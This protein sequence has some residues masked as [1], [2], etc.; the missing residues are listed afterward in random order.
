MKKILTVAL[1]FALVASFASGLIT[2]NVSACTARYADPRLG[3][4]VCMQDGDDILNIDEIENFGARVLGTG[5][6]KITIPILYD[7]FHYWDNASGDYVDSATAGYAAPS[8][9]DDWVTGRMRIVFEDH[10]TA[11][12]FD[13]KTY[14]SFNSLDQKEA[15]IEIIAR[16]IGVCKG[17]FWIEFTHDDGTYSESMHYETNGRFIDPTINKEIVGL[18]GKNPTE[19]EVTLNGKDITAAEV[20]NLGIIAPESELHFLLDTEF[21]DWDPMITGMD[22]TVR[23]ST[24][25]SYKIGV[26]TNYIRGSKLVDSV[27]IKNIDGVAYIVVEFAEIF[28][29]TEDKDFDF[30][31][32]LT[33][34]GNAHAGTLVEIS[35]TLANEELY[36]DGLDYAYIGD[37]TIA[38]TDDVVRN[39]ELDL[40][41]GVSVFRTLMKD[42][43]YFGIAKDTVTQ[44]D[45]DIMDFYPSIRR[46]L[47]LTTLNLKTS[48]DIVKINLTVDNSDTEDRLP[49]NDGKAYYVYDANGKYLGTTD[50]MLPYRDVY[51][52]STGI[53]TVES[54]V[55]EPEEEIIDNDNPETGSENTAA[56]YLLASAL[57]ALGAVTA[58]RSKRLG[59][60]NR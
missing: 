42:K 49:S 3:H 26:K 36:V 34:R 48:G 56:P 32:W 11:A 25:D 20:S 53:I 58:Y 5:G 6:V 31:I 50:G 55:F 60:S 9:I 28:P 57:M 21:F 51:Y 59:G 40:G 41:N 29:S 24:L 12:I 2:L 14:I 7:G 1:A 54:A 37:G 33:Y 27:E 43:K 4:S 46:V 47:N 16:N 8:L 19:L 30:R 35:G 45:Q 38:R 17:E 13:E 52:L 18:T 44:N 39:I 23:K 15:R 22:T 10:A